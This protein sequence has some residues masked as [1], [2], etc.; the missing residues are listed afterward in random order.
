MVEY[1]HSAEGALQNNCL[2]HGHVAKEMIYWHSDKNFDSSP[3][4]SSE[5]KL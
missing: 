2:C 1:F 3:Y 4:W 5:G